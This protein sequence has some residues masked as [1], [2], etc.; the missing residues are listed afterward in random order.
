MASSK[1]VE[2]NLLIDGQWVP[3]SGGTYE[4]INPATEEVVGLAPNASV[5]DALAAAKAA[6]AAQPGWAATSVEERSEL[7][8]KAA[9][10]IREK[11]SEL[12]PW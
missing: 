5:A 2:E 8:L 4:I 7:M 10:A 3:A 12:L 11:A 1:H 6:R 9:E